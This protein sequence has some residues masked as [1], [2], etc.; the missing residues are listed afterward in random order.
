[1]IEFRNVTKSFE[2]KKIFNNFS[3]L[4]DEKEKV[5]LNAASGKGK[6]TFLKMLMG[7][8]K[9]DSGVIFI[10]N[11]EMTPQSINDIR[12]KIAYLPQ[13]III[14]KMQ[15]RDYIKLVLNYKVN[16]HIPYEEDH[17]I[18]HMK[19]LSL[20]SDILNQDTISISGGER[21]RL[22]I[23]LMQFLERK[24]F[25]LDEVTSALNND[26]KEIVVN[27]FLKMDKTVIIVSHDECWFNKNIRKLEW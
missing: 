12:A 25:L 17:I 2:T 20:S 1:M 16:R 9:V 5:L 8:I 19:L 15:V 22:G 26:L 10:D 18:R 23:I 3:C 14:P 7:Y 11:I 13:E 24:I 6:S 27:Y 21:Q 4:I